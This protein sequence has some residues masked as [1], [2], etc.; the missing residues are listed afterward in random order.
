MSYEVVMPRLG[1]N[2]EEGT[3]VEWL[4][5]DGEMVR[6][7]EAVCTIEG[8]KAVSDLESFESGFLK[9]PK[10]AP[11]PGDAVPVGTLLGCIV[12]EQEAKT[13]GR[14]ARTPDAGRNVAGQET[15]DMGADDLGGD[16]EDLTEDL[17]VDDAADDAGYMAVETTIGPKET[18]DCAPSKEARDGEAIQPAISPRAR[19][20]AR[21]SGI[22]WTLLKGSGRSGRIVERDILK[23]ARKQA[24]PLDR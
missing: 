3:L 22:D 13:F 21:A 5:Q 6:Q 14:D 18:S 24:D 8:D 20:V 12:S 7:G 9:I 23:A 16:T 17:A 1:W 11:Q 10:N 4:K 15:T 2:M 19:R